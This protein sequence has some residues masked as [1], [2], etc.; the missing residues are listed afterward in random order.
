MYCKIISYNR[1][2]W[3][4]PDSAYSSHI[5]DK[6]YEVGEVI[7]KRHIILGNPKGTKMCQKGELVFTCDLWWVG[8]FKTDA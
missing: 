8:I 7:N 4:V 5:A 2:R 6:V 1:P 3:A